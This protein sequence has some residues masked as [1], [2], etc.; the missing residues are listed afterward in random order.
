MATPKTTKKAAPKKRAAK[1]STPK[2]KAE[3]KPSNGQVAGPPVLG[4]LEPGEVTAL[5]QLR[6]QSEN[7]VREVGNAEVR[8]ARL[9]GNLQTAENRAQQLLQVIGTRLGIPDG[10]PWSVTS[11]GKAIL[12]NLPPGATVPQSINV[13]GPGDTPPGG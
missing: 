12:A 1:K 4:T 11:E 3:A 10:T 6:Q 8:K 7:L 2:K 5:Q 9:L 13:D